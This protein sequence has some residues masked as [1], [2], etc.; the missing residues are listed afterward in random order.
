MAIVRRQDLHL[1]LAVLM[2]ARAARLEDQFG[3]IETFMK[4]R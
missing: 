1:A 2:V 4:K 3:R